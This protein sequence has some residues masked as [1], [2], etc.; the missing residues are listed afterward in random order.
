MMANDKV[1]N[2]EPATELNQNSYFNISNR[3][4]EIQLCTL[5]TQE[6]STLV[7]HDISK[8]HEKIKRCVKVQKLFLSSSSKDFQIVYYEHN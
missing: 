5:V 4:P 2:D 6:A 8:K 7:L 3:W 1:R